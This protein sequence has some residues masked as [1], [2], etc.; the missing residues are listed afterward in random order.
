MG[1]GELVLLSVK[2]LTRALKGHDSHLFAQ[3]SKPGRVDVYRA[4]RT[5]DAAPH[6]I[7]SLTED[8]SLHGRPVEWGVDVVVNRI[9][10]HDLWRDDQFVENW[11]KQH[12]ADQ[13]S[14]RRTFRNSV[15]SFLYDFRRQFAKAT[16]EVNTS[17]LKKIHRKE[18]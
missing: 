11:I 5:F 16:N 2:R 7:F 15:E 12:E 3:E 14:E 6:Y 1:W 17:C 4:S 9:K 8:W 18:K 13:E 10:A